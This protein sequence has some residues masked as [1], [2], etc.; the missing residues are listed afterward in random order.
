MSFMR[1]LASVA[2]GFAAA[3]GVDK[4]R[5]MG[6]MSGLQGMMSG[7]GATGSGASANP[8]A[9]LT[10]QMQEMA[11][12]MGFGGM[13]GGTPGATGAGNPMADMMSNFTNASSQASEAGMAGLG[14]LMAA[15]QGAAVSAGQS[16]DEMTQAMFKGTPVSVAMEENAKLMLR[17][18][19]QAAKA[20]GEIDD[21]EREQ[22]LGQLGE[23]SDEERA[24]VEAE[25]AAPVDPMRLVTDAGDAVKAQIYAASL[26]AMRVDTAAEASYLDQLAQALALPDAL[27]QRVHATMGVPLHS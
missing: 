21:E 24:F 2:V 27:R 14:G 17:A 1:T 7:G 5:K 26:T 3:K 11:K 13:A 8:M 12:K 4:Y 6:G 18:M 10:G 16:A 9:A 23:V 22:I 25:L 19:I 15:F 20:D